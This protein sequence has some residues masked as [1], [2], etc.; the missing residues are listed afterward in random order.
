[1][2]GRRRCRHVCGLHVAA[3]GDRDRDGESVGTEVLP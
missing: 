2:P 3:R 1:M